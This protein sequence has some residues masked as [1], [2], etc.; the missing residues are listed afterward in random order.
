MHWTKQALVDKAWEN[1][2]FKELVKA[3]V[4]ALRG[5]SE[6]DAKLLKEAFGVVTIDDLAKLKYVRW[7][8]GIVA[9]AEA[10]T[11]G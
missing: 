1:M 11:E 8:Q 10:D 2:S 7:A 9:L 6:G 4:D 5:V 3:P